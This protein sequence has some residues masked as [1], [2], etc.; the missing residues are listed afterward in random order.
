MASAVYSVGASDQAANARG[1]LIGYHNEYMEGI[2]VPVATVESQLNI[3][4]LL[5]P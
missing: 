4:V 5:N 3:S 1:M 2:Y